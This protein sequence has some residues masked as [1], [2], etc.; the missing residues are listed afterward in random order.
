[1]SSF[2]LKAQKREKLGSLEARRIKRAGKIPAVIHSKNGNLNISIDK[3]EFDVEVK[4]GNIQ[5]RV[6][7]IEV[8]GK[9]LKSI[10]NI[11]SCDPVSDQV[12]HVDFVNCTESDS[13]KAWPK[14]VF[15]GREKSPGIKRGGFLNIRA[16]KVEVLCK[17][18]AAIP[19]TIEID[20]SK[21]QVGQKIRAH[22]I[23]LADGVKFS[24]KADFLI[25]SITGRG[26]AEVETEAG[27]AAAPEAAKAA[28][29]KAA[30]PKKE[31][32][33]K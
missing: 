25:A 27:A 2:Q 16:R 13:V 6:A 14:L 1:M 24:N 8:D 17:N 4:K 22:S 30:A 23:S 20:I 7:E 19:L 31:E 32:A 28:A 21:V 5:A 15:V 26:K 3:R 10:A 11:I 29:T 18:E 9:K 12:I 33:K